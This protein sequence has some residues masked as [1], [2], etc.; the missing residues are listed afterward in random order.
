MAWTSLS[1][2]DGEILYADSHMNPLQDNFGAMAAQESGAPMLDVSCSN[3][4]LLTSSA[5]IND[6]G[7]INTLH[8][9]SGN[10]TA[11][12]ISNDIENSS[13]FITYAGSVSLLHVESGS[14]NSIA[15]NS[16]MEYIGKPFFA[17]RAW[18]NFDGT[19]TLSVR[20]SGNILGIADHATG[21]YTISF[22]TSMIDADYCVNITGANAAGTG[23]NT[24]A[25]GAIFDVGSMSTSG[26]GVV[27]YDSQGTAQRDPK[28]G[29]ITVFR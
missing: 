16:D 9:S 11:D 3:I 8:V 5:F 29:N 1:F 23:N 24:G 13:G 27:F 21:D 14:L 17:C 19:G 10:I 26:F 28:V 25:E 18:V 12:L 20:A 2:N 4:N 22:T 6:V 7:S 15:V